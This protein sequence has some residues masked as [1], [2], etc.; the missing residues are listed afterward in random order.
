M[1]DKYREF[2]ESFP[3]TRLGY[4]NAVN[5]DNYCHFFFP[6]GC[7]VDFFVV[8]RL[9]SS[10]S[11]KRGCISSRFENKNGRYYEIDTIGLSYVT[12]T[13]KESDVFL[14]LENE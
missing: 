14:R 7:V 5:A 10:T 4:I 11:T 3:E 8:D 12:Y 6:L 9:T 13:V 2:R 1:S